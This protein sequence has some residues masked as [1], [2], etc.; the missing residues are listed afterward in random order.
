MSLFGRR[1]RA[2]RQIAGI[3]QEQLGVMLGLDEATS[4]TR[5]SRYERGTHTPPFE[6]AEK[7][8]SILSLPVE[9]FYC[10]DDIVAELMLAIDHMNE[11]ERKRMLAYARMTVDAGG[12]HET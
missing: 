2:A 3:S 1:L 8:A 10:R 5:I 6:L 4:S 12:E 9:Y 11:R 7:I